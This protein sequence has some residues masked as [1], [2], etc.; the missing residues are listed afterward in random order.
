[1]EHGTRWPSTSRNTDTHLEQRQA[2]FTMATPALAKHQNDPGGL[3]APFAGKIGD[4]S[5]PNSLFFIPHSSPSHGKPYH[6]LCRTLNHYPVA[7]RTKR[8][9]SPV[10]RYV[11][12]MSCKS[13]GLLSFIRTTRCVRKDLRFLMQSRCRTFGR[14]KVP[15]CGF[16]S[17][18]LHRL[19]FPLLWCSP[20]ALSS[21]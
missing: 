15:K 20:L 9:C 16:I 19:S 18:P 4:P 8:H 17:C 6:H 13:V 12:L 7:S 2:A 11:A 5:R 1:M 3:S 10:P 14:S 21:M